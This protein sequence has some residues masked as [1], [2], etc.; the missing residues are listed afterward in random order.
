M[1]I[2]RLVL[3]TV[4]IFLG[5][6]M[7]A[8]EV[9]DTLF[10]ESA[11][12]L[13]ALIKPGDKYLIN[14]LTVNGKL[15]GTDIRFIRE[16]AGRNSSGELTDGVL[17]VLDLSGAHLVEGGEPYFMD[18][19][20]PCCTDNETIGRNMFS[21]CERL[22]YV[23]LPKST[24]AIFASAFAEC[25][26]LKSINIPDGVKFIEENA[27]GLC[28]R[29]TKITIPASVDFI[30]KFAFLFCSRLTTVNIQPGLSFIGEGAFQNCKNLTSVSIPSSVAFIG[31]GA[32]SGCPELKSV[33][34]PSGVIFLGKGVALQHF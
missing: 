4:G 11:G 28:T 31:E 32:F 18:D 27:F 5:L 22:V 15:N 30:G 10:L 14:T 33:T 20:K 9:A 23:T 12:T 8:Q 13:P 34:F 21:G 25:S 6:Q 17:S 24:T 16:M 7:Q 2:L 19:E 1:K 3:I 29:L 26:S